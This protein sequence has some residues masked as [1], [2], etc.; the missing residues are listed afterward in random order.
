MSAKRSPTRLTFIASLAWTTLF[1]CPISPHGT[2]TTGSGK[3]VL[4]RPSVLCLFCSFT[5]LAAVRHFFQA[6]WEPV[7]GVLPPLLDGE[8]GQK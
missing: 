7:N 5:Q 3:I 2:N 4:T 6:P 1:P 8:M